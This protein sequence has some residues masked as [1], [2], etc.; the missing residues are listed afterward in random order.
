MLK[1]HLWVSDREHEEN[2]PIRKWANDLDN[3]PKK[4]SVSM[5]TSTHKDAPGFSPGRLR[6]RQ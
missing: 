5:Q 3:S 2:K 1:E 4:V 6:T